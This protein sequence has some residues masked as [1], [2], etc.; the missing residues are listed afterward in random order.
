MK[1]DLDSISKRFCGAGMLA[2]VA[3]QFFPKDM[4]AWLGW[5]SVVAII[6]GLCFVLAHEIV[7]RRRAQ[8][9]AKLGEPV[10]L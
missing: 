5:Y 10:S 8:R 4:P 7:S 3:Q 1:L 9:A 6:I 2:L